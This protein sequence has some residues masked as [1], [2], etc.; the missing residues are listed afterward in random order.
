MKENSIQS[1]FGK[2]FPFT[3]CLVTIFSSGVLGKNFSIFLR[4]F[5]MIS[6]KCFPQIFFGRG[7]FLKIVL[8]RF[9]FREFLVEMF[10]PILFW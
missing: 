6:G 8:W 4:F 9:L 2:E 7:F 10:L 5:E 3:D 1:M